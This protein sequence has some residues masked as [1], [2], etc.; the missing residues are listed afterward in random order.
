MA[1]VVGVAGARAAGDR[2]VGT[3]HN[4]DVGV[5]RITDLRRRGTRQRLRGRRVQSEL[6]RDLLRV[7]VVTAV[8]YTTDVGTGVLVAALAG[9]SVV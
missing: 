9:S 6:R 2:C 4:H 3:D 8:K 5:L 7:G 1:A